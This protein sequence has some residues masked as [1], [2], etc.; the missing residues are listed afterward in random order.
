MFPQDPGFSSV[1]QLTI[2]SLGYRELSGSRDPDHCIK[3]M[4]IEGMNVD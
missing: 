4:L 1:L 2:C 3:D